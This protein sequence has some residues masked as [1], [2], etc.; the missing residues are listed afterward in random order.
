MHMHLDVLTHGVLVYFVALFLFHIIY[1]TIKIILFLRLETWLV[2][3]KVP[4]LFIC[5]LL[6]LVLVHAKLLSV[7]L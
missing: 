1:L 2:S 3:F 7:F 6:L 4:V 5:E